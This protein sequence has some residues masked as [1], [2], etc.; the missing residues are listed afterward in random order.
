MCVSIIYLYIYFFIALLDVELF[1]PLVLFRRHGLMV[2]LIY[3]NYIHFKY[4]Y[5]FTFT[6]TL[7]Y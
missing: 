3:N 5:Y 1:Y 4:F 2:K 6:F 7:I